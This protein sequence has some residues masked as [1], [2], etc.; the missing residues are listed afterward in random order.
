MEIPPILSKTCPSVFQIFLFRNSMQISIFLFTWKGL[1]LL[2]SIFKQIKLTQFKNYP[3]QVFDFGSKIVGICGSNGSGKTNL[4]DSL[5][6]LCFTRSYFT[7]ADGKNA[8]HGSDGFRLEAEVQNTQMH[9][10]CCILRESGKK[11]FLLDQEPYKKFSAHI[12]KFSCVM[13]A[14]DDSQIITGLSEL[15]RTFIDTL[16][17]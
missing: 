1:F 15:R 12:G 14:P 10:L 8:L 4:L 9:H 11:E 5:Y 17:S 13:I 3:Y 6:Y 16:L 2:V 7:N